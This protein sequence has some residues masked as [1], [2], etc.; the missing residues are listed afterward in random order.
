[1]SQLLPEATNSC[2]SRRRR[3]Q[4]AVQGGAGGRK[5]VFEP[6]GVGHNC[7]F[8]Q[9]PEAEANTAD[10]QSLASSRM[11]G[12][13]PAASKLQEGGR[14]GRQEEEQLRTPPQPS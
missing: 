9:V 1:M 3:R 2:P 7:W 8:K 10:I 4:T 12:P 14:G 6:R 5:L 13:T 11:A